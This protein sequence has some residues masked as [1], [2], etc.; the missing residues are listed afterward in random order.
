MDA[1]ES[2]RIVLCVGGGIAAYKSIEVLRRL[3]D[4]GYHVVPVLS[5]AA[6]RFVGELTFSAL[7]SEPAKIDLFDDTDPI[8]HTHLGRSADLVVVA[9]ATADLISKIAHGSADDLVSATLLATRAPIVVAPAMHDE[10]WS[11]PAVRRNI[12]MLR[13]D[14]IFVVD[15]SEGRL[16]GGDHGNGRMAEPWVIAS[17][18]R[19]ILSPRRVDLR[20]R[21]ILVTAGGT[22]EAIDPVR[23]VGNSSSGKQGFALASVAAAWGAE[24]ELVSTVDGLAGF[25]GISVTKVVSASE[26]HEATLDLVSE[27]DIVLMAAAVADFR[28]SQ[29]A[30]EKFKREGRS[31]WHVD[32]VANDDILADLVRR[33][34]DGSVVVGFAA[35]TSDLVEHAQEKL[36]RKQLDMIVANDVS[37]E[38]AGFDGDTNVVVIVTADGSR[39]DLPKLEKSTV[40]EYVLE[41]AYSLLP[42]R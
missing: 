15:P 3:V 10:M 9:P 30:T 35:E 31:E 34:R 38:G 41:K 36:Q 40:A 20:S 6:R 32:L 27:M 12:S 37:V 28:P 7:G 25:P 14:G 22:R 18:A 8:P 21:R 33:R 2:P 23:F 26:M 4:S 17:Y 42:S 11:N 13:N 39:A 5:A 16:A 1:K 29:S 19:S 24:V